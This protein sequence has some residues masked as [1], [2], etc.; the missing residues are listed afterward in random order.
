MN[1][2]VARTVAMLAVLLS[3]TNILRWRMRSHHWT[4]YFQLVASDVKRA[5]YHRTLARSVYGE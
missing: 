2:R 3:E 5:N 1:P 4:R